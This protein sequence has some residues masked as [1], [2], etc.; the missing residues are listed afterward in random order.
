MKNQYTDKALL[1]PRPKIDSRNLDLP[2]VSQVA[3]RAVIAANSPPSFFRYGTSI[4]EVNFDASGAPVVGLLT[5]DR[6][7]SVLGRVA[8]WYRFAWGE[9][10]DAL[11]PLHVVRDMLAT[12]DIP[13][14]VLS[15]IVEAPV[16]A[17]DGTLQTYP[18]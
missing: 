1:T 3:W 4:A 2:S 16:F 12:P 18:G 11:P 15:R 17:P 13:L 6:M 8:W 10:K 7:R 9:E 14:P 5:Q